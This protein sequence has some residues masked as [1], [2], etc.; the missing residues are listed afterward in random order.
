MNNNSLVLNKY[1]QLTK[2]VKAAVSLILVRNILLLMF[3]VYWRWVNES[4]GPHITLG[5]RHHQSLFGDSRQSVT[6]R[7]ELNTE[8]AKVLLL[9]LQ[10]KRNKKKK[11]KTNT[12]WQGKHQSTSIISSSI[13]VSVMCQSLV[14]GPGS[15]G[16][17]SEDSDKVVVLLLLLLFLLLLVLLLLLFLLLLL[18]LLSLKGGEVPGYS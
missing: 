15:Y 2:K 16:G 5:E 9:L 13:T 12:T 14:P 6:V 3:N 11:D 17:L 7:D 18:L 10:E 8:E 1:S 4:N